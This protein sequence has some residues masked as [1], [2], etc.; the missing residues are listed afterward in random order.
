MKLS[1]GRW[2]GV[3]CRGTLLVGGDFFVCAKA[4]FATALNEEFP[5]VWFSW[6]IDDLLNLLNEARSGRAG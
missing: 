2:S 4:E 1:L 3:R 5:D 6:I